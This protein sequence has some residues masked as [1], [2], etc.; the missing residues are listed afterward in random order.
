MKFSPTW[1][2]VTFFLVLVAAPIAAY[3]ISP[4]AAPAVTGM[5]TTALGFLFGDMKKSASDEGGAK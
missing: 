5:V 4:G 3:A 2:Q 1:Q